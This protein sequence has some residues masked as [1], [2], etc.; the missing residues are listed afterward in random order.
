LPAKFVARDFVITKWFL[1]VVSSPAVRPPLFSLGQLARKL[2]LLI[3][4]VL[5]FS[6]C[7]QG[8]WVGFVRVPARS[9]L[10]GFHGSAVFFV[11]FARFLVGS[12]CQP[13]R[14]GL[15]E[16]KHCYASGLGLPLGA[17]VG[18]VLSAFWVG[19]VV[20]SSRPRLWLYNFKC[21][22]SFALC[23]QVLNRPLPGFCPSCGLVPA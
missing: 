2:G 15:V 10:A 11:G 6:V 7:L 16:S 22:W 9:I 14:G 12:V 5:A 8:F 20:F 4:S 1:W 3:G 17:L 21:C 18:L 23:Q 19:Q 13:M